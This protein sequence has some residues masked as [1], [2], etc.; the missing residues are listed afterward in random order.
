MFKM[1]EKLLRLAE[2]SSKMLFIKAGKKWDGL[3]SNLQSKCPNRTK[4][5]RHIETR[6]VTC[7]GCNDVVAVKSVKRI[8]TI[9]W[10]WV[11]GSLE[12]EWRLKCIVL[13]GG[14]ELCKTT[15]FWIFLVLCS[16]STYLHRT[17]I[18]HNCDV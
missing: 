6:Y 15:M 3:D 14:L 2:K 18:G 7:R 4:G 16:L 13:K 1:K 17:G 9:W 5:S 12:W 8:K 11:K 10:F